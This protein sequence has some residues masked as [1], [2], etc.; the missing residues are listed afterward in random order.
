M[1]KKYILALI[2]FLFITFLAAFVGNY[3]TMPSIPTWYAS[4]NKPSFSPPNWLFGP[5][6]TVLYIL[7]TVSAFLIWQKRE[8]PQTKKALTFY[9]IQLTLNTLW[10]IIFF[11]WHNL[12]LAFA[13]IVFLWFFILLTLINFYKVKKLTGILFIPYILW[14][15]FAA[16]LNFA[17]WQLNM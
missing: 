12:G 17:I 4:L 14:V 6:W 11:G 16:I 15:S 2:F 10:S 1:N 9:F 8:N 7:M 13:E 3:F 5:A